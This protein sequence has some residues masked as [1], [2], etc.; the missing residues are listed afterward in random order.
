MRSILERISM[1]RNFS[2]IYRL[3]LRFA[4][5]GL[6][7]VLVSFSGVRAQNNI[8]AINNGGD[9]DD[10]STWSL[11]SGGATCNCEP[12]ANSTVHIGERSGVTMKV[13]IRDHKQAKDVIIYADG[14]LEWTRS[15]DLYI[16]N[17]GKI[18]VKAGGVVGMSSSW[19]QGEIRFNDGTDCDIIVDGD[20][21]IYRIQ[22]N[23][24]GTYTISGSMGTIYVNNDLEIIGGDSISSS[25]P[26]FVIN[27]SL[28][29]LS[30]DAIFTNVGNLTINNDLNL[31]RD[32]GKLYNQG[33]LIINDRISSGYRDDD[34]IINNSATG[35]IT[36]S[37]RINLSGGTR[38]FRINNHGLF[39]LSQEI[40]NGSTGADAPSWYNYAGSTANFADDDVDYNYDNRLLLYANYDANTINYNGNLNQDIVTPQDSCWHLTLSGTGIK[41][42]Q[43]DLI[44]NG[45]VTIEGAAALNP[46]TNNDDLTIGGNWTNTSTNADAFRQGTETVTFSGSNAQ[47]I[48]NASGEVFY[49]LVF[50]NSAGFVANGDIDVTG[51]LTM[52]DGDIDMGS[53]R[54]TL[55]DAV[56]NVGIFNYTSG[57]VIGAFERWIANGSTE[58][59]AFPV[60]TSAN[61]NIATIDLGPGTSGG[62]LIV[63]F[64][65]SD[66]GS[67]GLPLTDDLSTVSAAFSDGYWSFAVANGFSVGTFDL[68]LDGSGMSSNPID[69]YTR[70][71]TRANAGSD[72][73]VE[74]THLAASDPLVYR[75]G[76]SS[77]SAEFGLGVSSA[78]PAP[79]I[80][81][82]YGGGGNWSTATTWT[83]DGS[84]L[85]LIPATGGVPASNDYVVIL[86]GATVVMDADNITVAS[87]ELVGN[88]QVGTTSGH[89][90]TTISG[91]GK[92]FLEG[93]GG[94]DNFPDGVATLFSD[95]SIGGTVEYNGDGN[96][97][98]TLTLGTQREFNNFILNLDNTSDE[99]VLLNDMI[100]NGDFTLTQG[101]FQIN[102]NSSSTVLNLTVYGSALV[103]TNATMSVGQ[104]NTIGSYTIQGGTMPGTGNYHSIFHQVKF[105]GDFTNNGSVRFT[106]QTAPVYDEFT[107]T[108][109]ATVRFFG[110]ANNT[111]SLFG[112]TDF[113][114]LIIDKGNDQTYELEINSDNV[115]NIALYGPNSVGRVESAPFSSANPEVRKALWIF[116]GTLHLTGNISIPTLSEGRDIG[117]NGDYPIG[118]NGALWIDGANVE[119]YSTADNT[120]Q[121]PAGAT[122]I[123]TGGSH[124]ALSLYGTFRITNGIFGTRASAGFIFWNAAAGN[125][126]VEGG[127]VNVSQFR[128]AGG[129]TGTNSYIQSGGT[130]IVRSNVGQSGDVATSYALFSMHLQDAV[131]NMSGGTLQV[132]GERGGGSVFINSGEGYYSVTGGDLMVENRNNTNAE[133]AST[134]PFWNLTLDKNGGSASQIELITNTI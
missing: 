16:N 131:F 18:D 31:S 122:G 113:Y 89:D 111:V 102:D 25:H 63:E 12:D 15:R 46:D 127:T 4:I 94:T 105:G 112:T 77:L 26:N 32:R 75:A 114:N 30:N 84:G 13:I 78:P 57:T 29:Y 106:N 44:I 95:A 71:L 33:T 48:T 27:N 23:A 19:L 2:G 49:D 101:D 103:N 130:V 109:A 55:G 124:Q 99:V 60:G 43:E 54:L 61:T 51:S 92:M 22:Y 88:L 93:S 100:I 76:M 126:I 59:L 81:Y 68:T 121:I 82:S 133:I 24:S 45:N 11:S 1:K 69:Q 129:G 97:T 47:T 74:G 73:S 125:V 108:G 52:T 53:D 20:L 123:N 37:G 91:N 86:S 87:L 35:N 90:F 119:V 65:D 58:T 6:L 83:Q 8:Y 40:R 50:D 80:W 56:T 34:N 39:N 128:S 134:V 21:S 96:G 118:Q 5:I 72:W 70:I 85:T 117:G 14:E 110:A 9:W 66:P 28:E 104:G 36:V 116:N 7:L 3:F 17:G 38:R 107:S 98:G 67:S 10:G 115:T 64:I 62:S 41:E 120:S 42:T 79:T 132:Y